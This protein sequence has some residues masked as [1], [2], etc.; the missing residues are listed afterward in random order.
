MLTGKNREKGFTIIELL[1]VLAIIALL[2]GIAGPIT[3]TALVKAKESALKHDL[4]TV[5]KAIDDYYSDNGKYPLS[6]AVL[7]D[8]KY[9]RKIPRDPVT[10]SDKTWVL[11]SDDSEDSE[12]GIADIK[13]GA[14]G[15]SIDGENFT[16]W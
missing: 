12:G 11:V 6:L 8:G 14:Q 4:A 2:A 10:D 3:F 15:I 16:D 1:V 13:S 5:R 7:V 9:I